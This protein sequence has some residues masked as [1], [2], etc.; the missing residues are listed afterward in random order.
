MEAIIPSELTNAKN[1]DTNDTRQI[2]ESCSSK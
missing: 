1:S 2:C